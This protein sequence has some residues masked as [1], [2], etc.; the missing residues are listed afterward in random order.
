MAHGNQRNITSHS[1]VETLARRIS[2]S[3]MYGNEA[4]YTNGQQT[5]VVKD[6]KVT[7]SSELIGAVT[8]AKDGW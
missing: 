5:I 6:A 4:T 7:P 8:R 3:T 1:A 2:S